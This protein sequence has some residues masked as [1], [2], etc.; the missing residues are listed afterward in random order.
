MKKIDHIIIKLIDNKNN[1]IELYFETDIGRDLK[2]IVEDIR[3][4]IKHE[5]IFYMGD[6][7]LKGHFKINGKKYDENDYFIPMK[8][9]VAF[10]WDGNFD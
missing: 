5:E 3:Y 4:E 1:I 2:E 9:I 7:N 6:C 10:T 8:N